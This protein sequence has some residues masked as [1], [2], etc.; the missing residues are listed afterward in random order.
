[1][2]SIAMIH[3]KPE[4]SHVGTSLTVVGST[5]CKAVVARTPFYDPMRL[6]SHPEKSN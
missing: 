5:E 1:M 4:F 6:R 2:L 3:I